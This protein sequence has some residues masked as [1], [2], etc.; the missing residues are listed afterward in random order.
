MAYSGTLPSVNGTL[1]ENATILNGQIVTNYVNSN[2]TDVKE[3]YLMVY[4]VTTENPHD[5][6]TWGSQ[7]TDYDMVPVHTSILAMMLGVP[8]LIC[9]VIG[10]A[11]LI[12]CI[13]LV[14][15]LR[16][17]TNYIV[18][19]RAAMDLLMIFGSNV[20]LLI[21]Y[22]HRTWKFG[23]P[24]CL[25]MKFMASAGMTVVMSHTVAIAFTRYL[26]ISNPLCYKKLSRPL[27]ISTMFLLLYGAPVLVIGPASKEGIAALPGSVKFDLR[28]MHC[29]ITTTE[30]NP[31]GCFVVIALTAI[32]MAYIFTRSYL[33]VAK[34]LRIDAMNA[35]Y[36]DTATGS[37]SSMIKRELT[38]IVSVC[39]IFV[40]FMVTY[41]PWPL[42]YK[43]GKGNDWIPWNAYML[44]AILA[45]V[46]SSANW[47]ILVSM[48]KSFRKAFYSLSRSLLS[49][50]AVAPE[51]N[52]PPPQLNLRH[53]NNV[54]PENPGDPIRVFQLKPSPL[55]SEQT[56]P[57]PHISAPSRARV[58]REQPVN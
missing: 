21:T 19:S 38:F 37:R 47:V 6:M 3:E 41:L 7:S 39:V 54:Y 52:A 10:N 22:A 23:G 17:T 42:L 44:V 43:I 25:F 31:W 13:I 56:Y 14:K 35:I 51:M 26:F 4:G 53:Q 27:R 18:L 28:A 57:V 5:N 12:L 11:P 58:E 48:N 29:I 30:S 46:P 50:A 55:R 33:V 15:Q 34:S 16:T 36:P 9:G 45:W 32:L 40:V 20:W 8:L 2:R 49:R 1:F 24:A